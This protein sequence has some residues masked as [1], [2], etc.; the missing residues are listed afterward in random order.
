MLHGMSIPERYGRRVTR[1][2]CA[3]PPSPLLLRGI[4]E[5]NAGLFFEA[6]ETW[7]EDWQQ[8]K[9]PQRDLL[10]ALIH[11]AAGYHHLTQR[12]NFRGAFIKL[13]SAIR[14]LDRFGTRCRGLELD[15]LRRSA[16][17]TRDVTLVLGKSRLAQFDRALLPRI[18]LAPATGAEVRGSG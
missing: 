16:R 8:E 4:E 2:R 6:H 11:L 1:K 13:G 14:L 7:E 9:G 3:E 10:R 17:L 18:N 15:A 5:F 12:H